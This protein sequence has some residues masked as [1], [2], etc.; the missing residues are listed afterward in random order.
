MDV[1]VKAEDGTS[2]EEGLSDVHEYTSSDVLFVDCLVGCECDRRYNQEH[3][4][5]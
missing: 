5:E 3:C 4:A 1:V 2:Q